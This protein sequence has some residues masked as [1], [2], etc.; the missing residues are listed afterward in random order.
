MSTAGGLGLACHMLVYLPPQVRY[1]V[2]HLEA[3]VDAGMT[4]WL[5]DHAKGE[6]ALVRHEQHLTHDIQLIAS[7]PVCV[8]VCVCVW[9]CSTVRS[10]RDRERA[11]HGVYRM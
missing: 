6:T 8:C 10:D 11:I 3:Q 5:G 2:E 4:G 9:S 7:T 1:L